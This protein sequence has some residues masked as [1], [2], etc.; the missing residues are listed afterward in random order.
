M[1]F[2]VQFQS[3][4]SGDN[5]KKLRIMIITMMILAFVSSTNDAFNNENQQ[6]CPTDNCGG[7]GSIL[8]VITEDINTD[9]VWDKTDRKYV[10]RDT[11]VVGQ[12]ATLTIKAGVK[13]YFDGF[14]AINVLGTL[15]VNGTANKRV[16]F[17][18]YK[19]NPQPS[20][21]QYIKLSDSS[22]IQYAILR[23]SD[24]GF[25]TYGTSPVIQHSIIE[26][27][28]RGIHISIQGNPLISDNVIQNNIHGIHLY[29]GDTVQEPPVDHISGNSILNNN[30]YDVFLESGASSINLNFRNNW[31]GT[32]SSQLI[33]AKIW[34][35]QDIAILPKVNYIPFLDGVNGNPIFPMFAPVLNP[36]GNQQVNL[37]TTLHLTL[38]ATDEN[39]DDHLTFSALPVPLPPHMN[40]NASTGV[41]Q[42]TPG[43]DQ[44]GDSNITFKVS[45]GQLTDSETITITVNEP[46]PQAPTSISGRLLDTNAYTEN[47]QEVGIQNAVI[48]LLGNVEQTVS[49]ANGYFML[50]NIPADVQILDINTSNAFSTIPDVIYAGFREELTLIAGV[51]NVIERPVFLPRIDTTGSQMIDPNETIEVCNDDIGVCITI[52]AHT[53]MDEDGTEFDGLLSI[54]EVPESLAPASLPETLQPGFLITLQPV[55]VY[56]TSPRAIRFPNTD[57]LPVGSEL[58]IWS[59]DAGTGQFV[60][61][62]TG[63]VTPD[64]QYVESIDGGVRN[65]DWH[66]VMSPLGGSNNLTQGENTDQNL[67]S[68][69][70]DLSCGGPGWGSSVALASGDLI[71]DHT[72][73]AYRTLGEDHS[74]H[75]VYHSQTAN[76]KPVLSANTTIPVRSAV[77]N[78]IS[79]QLSVGGV[80]LGVEQFT[81]TVELSES[82]DET[83]YVAR[84][85]DAGDLPTGRY[86]YRLMLSSNFDESTVSEIVQ[87]D[88]FVNN[89]N[90]SNFG[91]GWGIS[92]LQ[93]IEYD[94][95][96]NVVLSNG[97]GSMKYFGVG[98]YALRFDGNNDLVHF[99]NG[100]NVGEHTMEAWIKPFVNHYGFIFSRG[101][102][103]SSQ[104]TWGIAI[105]FSTDKPF[106]QVD[107]SGPS[108]TYI[109]N[110]DPIPLNEWTHFAATWKNG[111]M[112]VYVNG[113]F[114]RQRSGTNFSN[115]SPML[116]GAFRNNAYG[117]NTY[118][119]FFNGEIDEIRY[120]SVER[121]EEEIWNN[122]SHKLTGSESGLIGSWSFDEGEGQKA[123]NLIEGVH[124]GTLGLSSG[125]DGRDPIWV[126]SGAPIGAT[127]A[128]E[129]VY[130]SPKG[131]F[132]SLVRNVDNSFTRTMKD[133]T[134]YQ[135]NAE[136]LQTS[137]IDRNGNTTAYTYTVEGLLETIIDPVGKVTTFTYDADHKLDFVT[138]PAG[139]VTNFD[140]D[141]NGNLIKIIDPDLSEREFTYDEH[142]LL[143][144]QV[145]KRDFISIYDYNFADQNTQVNRADGTIRKLTP[146]QFAGLI[147]PTGVLG[148]EQFPIPFTRPQEAISVYT[149]GRG[150]QTQ[151][152]TNSFGASTVMIDAL[153]HTT[154]IDRDEN[155]N[156]T[157]IT[158]PRGNGSKLTYDEFGNV[159]TIRQKQ[160]MTAA[161]NNTDD[162]V[163]QLTYE[164]RFN[165]VKTMTDPR[166]NTMTFTFDYELNQSDP[167]Y[168]EAG[169]IV[170]ITYPT[171]TAGTPVVQL[172]YNARGQ[173]TQIQDPNGI[174]TT[175]NYDPVDGNLITITQDPGGINAVTQI[176]YDAYG[177]PDSITDANNHTTTILYDELNR[178]KE[179][180]NPLNY[181]TKFTYEPSG[182]V[183]KIER[184][185]DESRV[186]FQTT[187][188]TYDEAQ[189]LR[190]MTDPLNRVTS[191]EYDDNGNMESVLDAEG[192][193]TGYS[194]DARN[195]LDTVTDANSPSGITD[196]DYDPNRNL[197]QII[198]ANFNPTD[199]LYDGF[200]R[201]IRQTYA[202]VSFHQ[203]LYDKNSN[204]TNHKTP[205]E[206]ENVYNI[207]FEYDSLNRLFTVNYLLSPELNKT[208]MYDVG[209]RLTEA[210]TTAAQLSFTYDNLNRVDI[211]TSTL[212]AVPYTLDYDYDKVNNQ[213][214]LI[215]PSGKDVEYT[216]DHNDRLEDI[217]VNS[218]VMTHYR[219]DPLDRILSKEY[220]NIPAP[221]KTTYQFD[222]ANQLKDVLNEL[223][224]GP[225][226][227]RYQYPTY[228]LVG[229]RKQMVAPNGTHNYS[230]NDIYELTNVTGAQTHDFDYDIVGNRLTADAIP[231]VPNNLN[232]Y[233]S[234]DSV[235]YTYDG[236]GNLTNDGLRTFNFDDQNR[237][238]SATNGSIISA[239]EYDAFNRRVSKTV[240]GITTYYVYDQN[241]VIAEYDS[242]GALLAEY[243]MGSEI[244]EVLTMERG[245]NTYYYH[246]DGLGSVT[247]LTDSSG[248][249]VENY[250]YD[251]YGNMTSSLS[252][253]GNPYYFTGRRW[254]D[255]T[256]IY[257]YRAR[258]YVPT[259]GRF[260]SR[261]P[262][263]YYDH[264]NLYA[265]TGND[266]INWIDPFGLCGE[267][268][269]ESILDGVQTVLDV[270][271]LIPGIGEF[272]DLGNS[273][274][275]YVRDDKINALLSAGAAVPFIGWGATVGKIGNKQI[276]KG[277]R[278]AAKDYFRK[279]SLSNGWKIFTDKTGGGRGVR[280]VTKNGKNIRIR[281]KRDGTTRIQIN[282]EKFIFPK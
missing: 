225:D 137:M 249:V 195:L 191:F 218:T 65:N 180:T 79:T 227:S 36:V 188:L 145:S 194:Y 186:L 236:N 1:L 110:A 124:T 74:L 54:S 177:N 262:I 146:A 114:I 281:F 132:S 165:R 196:Y 144:S 272:F 256:G 24:L 255:E 183:K 133:G 15:K 253:V 174:I 228:D 43:I 48:K 130:R 179:L 23:H 108:N 115:R 55:G 67:C 109:L 28:K 123:Y 232:Q 279:N 280:G 111:I 220:R 187:Q 223:T 5:M 264:M 161:D 168:A 42:F 167:R 19:T 122:M 233:E 61:V 76:P 86:P 199:Y 56:Y 45:D 245:G 178:I 204:L 91:A 118:D 29:N 37:G 105:G 162:I 125:P 62:G 60:V 83:I 155:A 106:H 20:D 113:H 57:H 237:L 30:Q 169:N 164:P 44:V 166:G 234:V 205:S 140:I 270:A 154:T 25:H 208:F 273:A 210:N 7:G 203:Y 257:Y 271:G 252:S 258:M 240:D 239:Y 268:F 128:G 222:F 157:A 282:K 46:D 176:D 33:A 120:W 134:I 202:D 153:N 247:E 70:G 58:D 93:K 99:G 38:T 189:R 259:I 81:S 116:A 27:N 266:P 107:P 31:W 215:Y 214:G 8:E 152:T 250:T 181:L 117:A 52:D 119:W 170:T 101:E 251:P 229:N 193:F 11:I 92:G 200:D 94:V 16:Q 212:N 198:D 267:S 269:A 182:D 143:Q 80:D 77:P 231:Y 26:K 185:A 40:L 131:D 211:N 184:Q 13:V 265:Y 244:D 126:P 230:Y 75:F 139:R 209:S 172:T 49:D 3:I 277:G 97:D 17:Q 278:K 96:N 224:S 246:Y 136:G 34:D 156:P 68:K 138:D 89:K 150:Y 85:F 39:P 213:T 88:I 98:G 160:D 148:T 159:L 207:V 82:Q 50:N 102:V 275:Y 151:Y 12:N 121:T 87:G 32:V 238:S 2:F 197:R 260:I 64:G 4:I 84:Q 21:W 216:Y 41:F 47:G 243:V 171:V 135:F 149:D 9:T 112:K 10:I 219:Y 63:Q 201:L 127:Q 276:L 14:Y 141:Q 261:D 235:T 71:E 173:V 163:T 248:N 100:V 147:D 226:I 254:D 103:T 35:Q 95:G 190:T 53:A 66:M 263:G 51:E 192:N 59:L 18:S 242:A 104:G 221:Q 90:E 158:Q 78:T 241:E 274:I 6:D 206:A 73:A 129:Q 69:A 142:H 175:Y 22:N 72:T 217:L